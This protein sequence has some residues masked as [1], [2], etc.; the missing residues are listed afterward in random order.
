MNASLAALG[1]LV[2]GVLFIMALRGLSS[3]ATS[4]QGNLMGMLGMLL[5]VSIT[6]LELWF[7]DALDKTTL[8]LIGGGVAI[9]GVVGAFIARVVERTAERWPILN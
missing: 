1:Y 8:A 3:P 5:A 2:S 6:G 4:R 9:G 7:G